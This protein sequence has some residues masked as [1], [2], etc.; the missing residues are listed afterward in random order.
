MGFKD[1]GK[2]KFRKLDAVASS[3]LTNIAAGELGRGIAS[4][5]S[6][7]LESE[8]CTPKGRELWFIVTKYFATGNNAEAM[9]SM[10]DL[11]KVTFRGEKLEGFQSSWNMILD[12]LPCLPDPSIL[13]DWYYEQ[14]KNCKPID[15]DIAHYNIAKWRQE[16]D[17]CYNYPHDSVIPHLGLTRQ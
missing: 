4:Y 17:G 8:T 13:E 16:A 1:S 12:G 9:Y 7:A 14:I 2:R 11:R 15:E 10:I 6:H 3:A 5:N